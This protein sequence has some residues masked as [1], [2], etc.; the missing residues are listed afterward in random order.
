MS[1]KQK[2]LLIAK[3]NQVSEDQD[4]YEGYYQNK[5]LKQLS[6]KRYQSLNSNDE[7]DESTSD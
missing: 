1:R 2:D 5:L 6:N 4:N 3:L 7:S